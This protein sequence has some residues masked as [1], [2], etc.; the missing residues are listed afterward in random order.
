MDKSLRDRRGWKRSPITLPEYRRGK[1]AHNKGMKL[2]AEVLSLGEVKAMMESFG[3]SPAGVRNRAMAMLMYRASLK[4]G[5][6][7][8]LERHHYDRRRGQL[9]M[10]AS[11]YRPEQALV[12]DAQTKEALDAWMDARRP[13][14]VSLSA[15]MFCAVEGPSKGSRIHAAYLRETLRKKAEVL[16]IDRR[17]TA[18]GLKRSGIEHRARSHSHVAAHLEQYF[19]DESFQI[20]FPVAFEHWESALDQFTVHPTRHADRIGHDCRAAMFSFI[21]AALARHQI[22]SSVGDGLVTKFRELIT[23]AGPS[24]EAVSAHLRALADYW[25]AISGLANRQE[26]AAQREG[27]ALGAPDSQRLI[28]YTMLVMLE[29]DR[30]LP[31]LQLR[32]R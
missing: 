1:P 22:D 17:V 4:M 31:A 21:D 14:G 32:G 7:V 9:S 28:F 27:E 19:D 12:L 29:I 16:G 6:V 3:T 13:V 18:Q 8:A 5:Q 24:S 30:A 2:P 15:P 11:R 20:R 26:H 25:R 23:Q 10:P